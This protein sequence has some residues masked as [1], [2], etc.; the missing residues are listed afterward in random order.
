[1][2]DTLTACSESEMRA[3]ARRER[4]RLPAGKLARREPASQ[5]GDRQTDAT[6]STNR[7]IASLI[8]ARH[9]ATS[10][11]SSGWLRARA[12]RPQDGGSEG[13]YDGRRRRRHIRATN[14]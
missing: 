4:L 12:N 5:P 10:R 3:T 9:E 14:L 13:N 2:G 1:M 7:L 8:P 6:R 11:G